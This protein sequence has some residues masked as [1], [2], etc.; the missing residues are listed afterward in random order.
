MDGKLSD[1]FAVDVEV[2]LG[3]VMSPWLFNIFVDGCMRELK[4]KVGNIGVRQKL[5]GVDWSVV[6]CLLQMIL[7]CHQR[8]KRS[9]KDLWISFIVCVRRKL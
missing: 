5:N 3:C 4:A 1:G 8:V 9:F 7:C 6:A 2:R